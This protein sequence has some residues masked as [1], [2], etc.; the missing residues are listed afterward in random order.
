M[1]TGIDLGTTVTIA[2]T[3]GDP[4]SYAVPTADIT[5]QL[6]EVS[7]KR[8][9]GVS[10]A[11]GTKATQILAQ[12]RRQI[13]VTAGHD[14]LAMPSGFGYRQR[15]ELVR[16]A[17]SAGWNA[18]RVITQI[19]AAG[20]A[21]PPGDDDERVLVL[22]LGASRLDAGIVDIGEGVC[23]VYALAE[24]P[25]A[26]GDQWRSRLEHLIRDELPGGCSVEHHV[27]R[28]AAESAM[29]DLSR[30]A[31]TT[32][33]LPNGTARAEVT[34]TRDT[35][36][37]HTEDLVLRCES[38]VDVLVSEVGLPDWI[39]LTGGASW[40][41]AVEGWAKRTIGPVPV[42]RLPWVS[43]A[44]GAAQE[45][46]VL[47][48]EVKDRL[49]LDALGLSIGVATGR[50]T[51]TEVVPRNFSIPS[52]QSVLLGS[53]REAQNSLT[54]SVVEG[55]AGGETVGGPLATFE[56]TGLPAAPTGTPHAELTIDIDANR[57]VR[58][59]LR[60]LHTGVAQ[61][62]DVTFPSTDHLRHEY[63]LVLL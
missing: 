46:G 43:V 10:P 45:A 30:G 1:T 47:S 16:A 62:L 56:L 19:G 24:D 23:C 9:L 38:V 34:I 51:M 58:A 50:R 39:A 3:L 7:F 40:I 20:L 60:S 15:D 13:P 31:S 17:R 55:D 4:R 6:E 41:S 14:V 59:E 63:P 22:D 53:T 28:A 44:A 12:L 42:R 8:R 25:L 49:L 2:C 32:V 57:L 11:E 18:T 54:V 5:G 29:A 36:E 33:V 35:F 52:K 26:G 48:G 37:H 21:L 61:N 27:V